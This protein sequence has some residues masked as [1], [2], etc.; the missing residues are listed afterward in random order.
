MR[1]RGLSTEYINTKG[2]IFVKLGVSKF[3]YNNKTTSIY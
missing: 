1:N 3:N 2:T